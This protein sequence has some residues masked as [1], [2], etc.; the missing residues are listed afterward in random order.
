MNW[1]D[2]DDDPSRDI[3]KNSCETI[4]TEDAFII[5]NSKSLIVRKNK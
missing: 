4:W 3:F 1:G 5:K 2:L